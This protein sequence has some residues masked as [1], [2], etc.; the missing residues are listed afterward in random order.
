[1]GCGAAGNGLVLMGDLGNRAEQERQREACESD[2]Q[3]GG[4]APD[5]LDQTHEHSLMEGRRA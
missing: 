4:R 3:P 5:E 2:S 1:M